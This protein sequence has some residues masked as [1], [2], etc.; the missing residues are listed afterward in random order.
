MKKYKYCLLLLLLITGCNR[1]HIYICSPDE[2]QCI[3]IIDRAFSDV[4]YV[5]DGRH[6]SIPDSNYV[7]TKISKHYPP[8][9]GIYI[10]WKNDAYEWEAIIERA[11]VIENRL[12]QSRFIFR[13]NLDTD[14]YGIPTDKRFKQEGC[15]N[16]GLYDGLRIVPDGNA[17]VEKVRTIYR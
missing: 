1:Q 11:T 6:T 9:D 8:S 13:D 3:T 15:V 17:I 14:E 4:R 10:C 5:I 12:D 2:S 16:V 7:K